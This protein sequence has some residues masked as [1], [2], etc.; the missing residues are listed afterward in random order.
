M[1]WCLKDLLVAHRVVLRSS[2]ETLGKAWRHCKGSTYYLSQDLRTKGHF[3]DAGWTQTNGNVSSCL[4]ESDNSSYLFCSWY[5]PVLVQDQ[6]CGAELTFVLLLSQANI[7]DGANNPGKALSVETRHWSFLP[8]KGNVTT[9]SLSL[10]MQSLLGGTGG[11]SP[12][13]RRCPS[14]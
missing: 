13:R 11:T 9:D 2:S 4:K 7:Q 10:G 8:A 6:F 3:R 5:D 1:N 14:G 12:T